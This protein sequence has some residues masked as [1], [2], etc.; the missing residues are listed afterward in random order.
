M[1]ILHI[2]PAHLLPKL[3]CQFA[4]SLER[5]LSS[6]L[7]YSPRPPVSVCG[8]VT[9]VTPA[10]AFLGSVGSLSSWTPGVLLMTPR[11]IV[12]SFVPLGVQRRH[13]TGL[14]RTIHVSAQLPS[15]V[16]PAF[17]VIHGGAGILTSFPSPTTFGL[18]LG[19]D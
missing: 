6:A 17:N 19:T 15:S 10:G 4:S 2:T 16:L 9:T 1:F 3:R 18:G 13:P 11:A 12:S 14:N 7:G 8:T 5:V